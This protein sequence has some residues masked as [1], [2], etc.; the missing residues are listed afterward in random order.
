MSTDWN[1][2]WRQAQLPTLAGQS[3]DLIVIGGGISG[4]GILREAARHGWRC[5][6]L[7]QR[8]FA[9]GT[10]SRSSK[11][12][13]GGLRYIAKGQWRL[14][15][16][17]VRERQRLLDEAPG[18]VEP[19]SFLMPHYRGVFPGPRVFGGLLAVYDAL[20]GRRNHRFHD[21]EQMRYLA[22]GIKAEGLLGGSCFLD[23]LTDDA[24]LVMRVLA[25]ARADGAQAFNGLRV[26]QVLRERGRVCGVSVEDVESG[27][28]LT[29]RCSVLAVASGAWAGRFAPPGEN[30]HLRPLRG[31]HLL[32]PGW[33]LPVAQ[34]FSFLHDSDRRPVFVFPWEGATVVGTTD[35]DHREDLDQSA[36]IS[37]EE[38]AYLLAA[39]EQQFPEARIGAADVLSTWSGVRPVVGSADAA[40][41]PSSE[42]REHALW[43]E[44]G[45]VTLA[46]GK[47]TT[48]RTQAIEVLQACAAMLGR[49][50]D[51]AD[52]VVFA[53]VPAVEVAGLSSG[54]LRRLAGRHGRDLPR[55][56]QWL[57]QLGCGC[58]ASSDTLWAELAFAAQSEMVLHLDDLLLRRT[59]LGLLLANGAAAELPAIRALCQPLLGWDDARWEQE[60]QRYHDLWL[61]YH[62]LPEVAYRSLPKSHP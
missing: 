34:A 59:R 18:L 54:Q 19:M 57:A 5:L 35:L 49:T 7:E 17:S 31:S 8:D 2:Q 16:D 20:A 61:R 27:Q 28:S 43:C 12:V 46:G 25:E 44:P 6:L 22:P 41:K 51:A 47:L 26:Q 3:W 53:A 21:V 23:A 10:S 45:C 15:R 50:L 11:M 30:R 29:L 42:T 9:W 33:R 60:Q 37:A 4:A 48:F 14:T 40:G 36:R 24:R 58:V 32:L 52:A 13:H 1:A 56:A 38:L 55:L 39:C 62:S